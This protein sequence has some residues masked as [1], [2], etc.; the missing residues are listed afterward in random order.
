MAMV[1]LYFYYSTGLAQSPLKTVYEIFDT[2][3]VQSP[4][5]RCVVLFVIP[6]WACFTLLWTVIPRPAP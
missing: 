2:L 1:R 4:G 6:S 5:Q 3:T